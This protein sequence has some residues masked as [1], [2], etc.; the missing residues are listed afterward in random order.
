ML[1][2]GVSSATSSWLESHQLGSVDDVLDLDL[3]A[4]AA[5]E[6]VGGRR[7]VDPLY[8]VCTNGKHDRCCARD[9]LPVAHELSRM[10]GSRV[11]ECSHVGGDRFAGNLVCLPDGHFY[12][13]VDPDA[14]RSIVAAN[15]AGEIE[16]DHW[17]GRSCHPFAIQ[18]AEALVRRRLGVSE[19][20]AL[21]V[22]SA[23]RDG[24]RYEVCFLR[25]GAN[26]VHARLDVVPGSPTETLTC[27]GARA[28]APTYSLV[29]LR[30]EV[31]DPHGGR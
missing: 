18:A 1:F 30:E 4:L 19:D 14:A 10:L 24:A 6:S 7:V 23:E 21:R 2:A 20:G 25:R 27:G 16:L 5:D 26:A 8:L 17:R 15:E 31:G 29:G 3:D 9:G 22:H 12:G 13:H 11:W 28:A